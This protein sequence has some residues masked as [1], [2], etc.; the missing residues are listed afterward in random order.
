MSILDNRRLTIKVSKLYYEENLSQ[1]EIAYL[2]GISRPQICRILT[3]ARES[4]CVNI[5]I[6]DPFLLNPSLKS[7]LSKPSGFGT[8]LSWIQ[9][10]SR[11][12]QRGA[13]SA[14]NAPSRSKCTYRTTALSAL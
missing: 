11:G 12:R 8:R 10:I 7:S 2:L 3:Y 6:E 9:G 13:R 5:R 4:G 1:K 14:R